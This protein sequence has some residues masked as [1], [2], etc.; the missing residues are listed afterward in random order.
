ML[1]LAG[2]AIL[3]AIFLFL[4]LRKTKALP[5]DVKRVRELEME[6]WGC[7]FTPA[8]DEKPKA[9]PTGPAPGNRH[10]NNRGRGIP[11]MCET[12]KCCGRH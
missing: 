5:Y 6:I 12:C 8:P 7:H 1:L 3:T 4:F 2:L 10:P 11:A 9:L